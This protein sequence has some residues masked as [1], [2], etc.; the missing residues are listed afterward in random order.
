MVKFPLVATLVLCACLSI[1]AAPLPRIIAPRAMSP[2]PGHWELRS[3]PNAVESRQAIELVLPWQSWTDPHF[4]SYVRGKF[5]PE[6]AFIQVVLICC[7]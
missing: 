2:S 5:D 6:R 3:S 1:L 4:Y 7:C